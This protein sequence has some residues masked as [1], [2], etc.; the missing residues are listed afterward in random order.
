MNL[1]ELQSRIDKIDGF[2]GAL[3]SR[4]VALDEEIRMQKDEMDLLSKASHVLKHM[5]DVMVKDEITKMAGLMTYGLKTIFEDQDLTFLPV[6]TRKNDKVHIELKTVNKGIEGEFGS[7]GGSVAVIE[8]FLL[9]ILCILK[10]KMARF[11]LLDESFAAVSAE[12]RPNTSK[13]IGELSKKLGL[14]ILLVTHE[15]EFPEFADHV[16]RVVETPKGLTMEQMK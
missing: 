3:K 14:D 16:Y 12:Y 8:S 6:M 9:R 7:F 15:K 10:M 13:L 4:Q 5:L 1:S 11:M 2:Y